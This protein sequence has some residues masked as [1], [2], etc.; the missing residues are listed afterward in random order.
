M[1][2]KSQDPRN[3]QIYKTMYVGIQSLS[4]QM[5]LIRKMELGN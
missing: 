4:F 5:K 1:N 2:L 3:S